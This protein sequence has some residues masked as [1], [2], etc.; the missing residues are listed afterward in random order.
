MLRWMTRWWHDFQARQE[1]R[2]QELAQAEALARQA[3]EEER[4]KKL[5]QQRI[6]KERQQRIVA[7]IEEGKVPDLD[8]NIEMPFNL[9]KNEFWLYAAR[10]VRYGEVKVKRE[11]VGRT[12]SSRVR[13]MKGLSVTVPG[14]PGTRVESNVLTPRGTGLFAISTKHLYFRGERSFPIRLARIHRRRASG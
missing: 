14:D 13:V 1:Q 7:I 12:R 8:L 6:T 9:Q 5:E 3:A 4:Q 10:N 2:R 11:V